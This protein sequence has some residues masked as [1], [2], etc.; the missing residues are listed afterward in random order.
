SLDR[1]AAVRGQAPDHDR[2]LVAQGPL[3]VLGANRHRD[4]A[5]QLQALGP[6]AATLQPLGERAADDGEEHVV[7]R[8]SKLVLDLLQLGQGEARWT[9]TPRRWVP[10]GLFSGVSGARLT[11]PQSTSLAPSAVS[12][13]WTAAWLGWAA[14][15]TAR[16]AI[17]NG[18]FTSSLTPRVT[19]AASVGSGP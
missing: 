15:L 8:A 12:R 2:D 1:V 5:S 3:L 13:S 9:P 7:D 18:A 19:T 10:I 14:F 4:G 17:P 11:V 16:S 6:R